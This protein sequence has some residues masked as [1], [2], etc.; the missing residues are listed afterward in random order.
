[1]IATDAA[2][3]TPQS[4]NASP[5]DRASAS[6]RAVSTATQ[7]VPPAPETST[8]R[9]PI[10]REALGGA[11]ADAAARLLDDDGPRELAREALQGR[12]DPLEIAVAAGLDDLHRRVEVDAH[13]VGADARGELRERLGGKRA[14]LDRADVAH[15]ERARRDVAHGVRGA[16]L[17]DE[18]H[19]ALAA[20]AEAVAALLGDLRELEV[21][22]ARA[23]RAA[24]HRC[25]DD[26]GAERLSRSTTDVST[27]S[28]ES[29]GSASWRSSTSSKRVV[30]S[31]K[32]TSPVAQ[33][34]M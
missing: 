5:S 14:R 29:S 25:D 6:A 23:L 27:A 10:L 9:T 20:E 22:L 16:L 18:E 2:V 8:W 7:E 31:R 15:D 24:C 30:F 1:V 19:R 13:G 11:G 32:P 26:R 12:E 17:L 33:S 4:R 21:D 34:S 28:S 3:G